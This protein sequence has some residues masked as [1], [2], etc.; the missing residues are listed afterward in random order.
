MKKNKGAVLTGVILMVLVMTLIGVPLL[1][2]VVYNYR[3]RE[4]SNSIK[5]AEYE[6]EMA[7]DVIA[8]IVRETV[9]QA[10]SD[11]K[12]AATT[13][14]NEIVELQR[15]N[16][17][18]LYGKY[19]SEWINEYNLWESKVSPNEEILGGFLT[20][21]SSRSGSEDDRTWWNKQTSTTK[22]EIKNSA[23]G[24]YVSVKVNE[25]L[26]NVKSNKL[27]NEENALL[28]NMLDEKGVIDEETLNQAYNTI[29]KGRFQT[30]IVSE[31]SDNYIVNNI[32][33]QDRYDGIVNN[34]GT[35]DVTGNQEV[36]DSDNYLKIS[37]PTVRQLGSIEVDAGTRFKKNS[38]TPPTTLSAT[39][40][41]GTPEF[42][43][44]SSV[45]QESITLSN[46]LLNQG[47]VIVG[48]K[49]ILENNTT[50]KYGND[51]TVLGGDSTND[52]AIEIKNGAKLIAETASGLISSSRVSTAKDIVLGGNTVFTTGTSPIYYRNLYVGNSDTTASIDVTFNGDAVAEDDLEINSEG[53]VNINQNENAN[54]YGFNDTNNKGPDSSS[55]IVINSKNLANKSLKLGNLYLAGRAFIEDVRGTSNIPI[56]NESGSITGYADTTYKTGESIAI[57]GNYLAYQTPLFDP[58]DS[59]YMF[60]PD[61]IIFSTYFMER[62]SNDEKQHAPINLADGFSVRPSDWKD[63]ESFD[64]NRKWK[65]FSE[66]ARLCSSLVKS[67]AV[68]SNVRY[69][70]GTAFDNNGKVIGS[71]NVSASDT[72]FRNNLSTEYEK[73]T[74][75]F[76]YRPINE[77]GAV[78]TTK[79]KTSIFGDNGWIKS[80]TDSEKVSDIEGGKYYLIFN[81]GNVE[82][83]LSGSGNKGIIICKGDLT[84]NVSGT[85]GFK[86]VLIVGG[87]LTVKGGT[88][89]L[90]DAKE[91]VINTII[92]N[93]L[94]TNTDGSGGTGIT[95]SQGSVFNKFTYDGSG[96]TYIVTEIGDNLININDLI[97]I[98]NW[99]KSN[100]GR[101]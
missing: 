23:M 2:M 42:D 46:A 101:L 77:T 39:F 84:L 10:I 43:S 5:R 78:D 47:G 100:Y 69:I 88:L 89:I 70:E 94:G 48:G 64:V 50:L 54:Y 98:T 92:G 58:T 81:N 3:L 14:V 16:Y 76:G 36:P 33:T 80:F 93:Y 95:G 35:I 71:S 45:T 4:L 61:K 62:K 86:G 28:G 67:I 99:K 85:A 8:V 82:K 6:N 17:S 51:I 12:D 24:D 38:T 1:G 74:K 90:E 19:T 7:M 31:F 72:S 97:G 20:L 34:G 66:Y 25:E 60:S 26:E 49:A 21:I 18:S 44:V 79:A 59:N 52:T 40:V 9:I 91:E 13:G 87:N 55:S 30:S 73:Y 32:L 53:A 63:G 41:I 75:Y 57:K 15:S 37:Q 83:T 29:F 11:A 56:Y 65:Y 68:T 27:S 22:E 96:S